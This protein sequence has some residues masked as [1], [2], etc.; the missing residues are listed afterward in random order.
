M[1]RVVDRSAV[2]TMRRVSLKPRAGPALCQICGRKSTGSMSMKFIRK[3]QTNTVRASGPT[4]ARLLALSMTLLAWLSTS[5]NR[6]STAAWKRPGTPEVA[7]RTPSH[8]RKTPRKPSTVAK[9]S[10]SRL[11][12]E[13]S[14]MVDCF[15][16]SNAK[17]FCRCCRWWVM[18][19]P[20]LGACCSLL[21]VFRDSIRLSYGPAQPP[22][23]P[24]MY[25]QA[26]DQR[27][28]QG[29]PA[30]IPHQPRRRHQDDDREANLDQSWCGI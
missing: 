2:G 30:Q 16:L 7:L 27:H 11:N 15:T 24:Q 14:T 12:R 8:S 26:R 17:F 1:P 25:L 3:I 10:E 4:K 29:R 6:I 20:A 18:Y 22:P 21:I 28:E 13:K 23:G 5:S 9:T 19:S